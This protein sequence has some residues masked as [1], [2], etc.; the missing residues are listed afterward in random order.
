MPCSLHEMSHSYRLLIIRSSERGVKRNATNVSAGDR[1]PGK[2]IEVELLGRRLSGE[3]SAPDFCA[4]RLIGKRKLHDESQP[5]QKGA[6]E[7]LFHVRREDG[8]PAICL[9]P[10]QQIANLDVGVTIV[11][12]FDFAAFAKERVGFVEEKHGAAF[13]GGIED[14]TQ[15]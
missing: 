3:N 13:L 14:A 15:I 2:Q 1:K 5:A 4:L 6:V 8:Q 9:H 7:G 12:V 11:A 10:L